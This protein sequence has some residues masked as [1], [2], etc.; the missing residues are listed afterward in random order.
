MKTLTLYRAMIKRALIQLKRYP[1]E[2]LSGFITLFIFFVFLFYAA[3]ALGGARVA[4][5]NTLSDIVVGYFVWTLTVITYSSFSEDMLQEAQ[6]GTLEQIAM[7]P[8]GLTRVLFGSVVAVFVFQALSMS[9]MLVAMMAVSGQWL[10]VDLVTVVPIVLLMLL[11]L[12]GV[13]YAMGGLALVFKRMQ[14]ANQILTIGWI[15][16]IAV[17]IAR[18]PLMKY[19]PLSWGNH[20]LTR[21]MSRGESLFSL[22][23]ELGFLA[24][25]SATYLVAG[26]LV[27]KQLER[28]ARS[29]GLLGHY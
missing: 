18:Y 13:G 3:K 14:S 20:L 23:G 6:V 15:A 28:F 10:N 8:L 25:H 21:S 2:T 19:L 27:F 5:G 29:R 26:I 11:G 9:V 12:S 4:A 1:F 24:V 7:S 22:L 17:P 16:L